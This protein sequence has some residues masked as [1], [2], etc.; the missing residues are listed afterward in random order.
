MTM[1]DPI[2]DSDLDAY[3]DNQLTPQRRLQVEAHL[4]R[5]P[6]SA[7]R[8]MGDLHLRGELRLS[9]QATVDPGG[10]RQ[11]RDAARRLESGLRFPRIGQQLQKVAAVGLLV[12]AGWVASTSFGP[13]QVTEVVASEPPPAHVEEAVRAHRTAEIRETMTSQPEVQ[14]YDRED[15]RAATA[16]IMPALPESWT[17][18]DVQV[19]PSRFGPSVELAIRTPDKEQMSLFAVRPGAFSVRPVKTYAI[20]GIEAA[21]WQI[22]DVAYALVAAPGGTTGEAKLAQTAERLSKTLY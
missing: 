20:D 6:E 10:T 4:A 18:V 22:G 13:F 1:A 14:T 9:L 5:N 19:F 2:L 3:V 8:V 15:I 7:A 16:I 21:D 12:G 11:T 17:V